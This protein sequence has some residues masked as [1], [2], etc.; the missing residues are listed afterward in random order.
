MPVRNKGRDEHHLVYKDSH[1][2][3]YQGDSRILLPA[4]KV[5]PSL[6]IADPP[7]GTSTKTDNKTRGRS[8]QAPHGKTYAY[9]LPPVFGDDRPF[10][11]APLLRFPRVMIFG[12]NNFT[13]S[14]PEKGSWIIWDKIDGLTSKRELGFNDNADCELIWT[15][16]KTPIRI[17]RHR[18]MGIMKGSENGEKRVHPTQKP[19]ALMEVLIRNFSLPGEL[20]LDPYVGSGPVLIAAKR[21]GR[22]SIGFEQSKEYCRT[23]AKRV[24]SHAS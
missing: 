23:A 12:A 1:V 24:V 13:H 5:T 18:W 4:L 22:R 16:I 3:I 6:V 20:I 2:R 11:P 10:D 19:I 17:I 15:N 7:Y 14:L 9:D 21:L 8:S